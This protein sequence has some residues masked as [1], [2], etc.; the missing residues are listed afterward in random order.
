M[1]ELRAEPA[2]LDFPAA[3]AAIAQSH[4]EQLLQCETDCYDVHASLARRDPGFVLVDVRGP[5]HFAAG[6]IPGAVNI[7]Y[8]QISEQTLARY[9]PNT[10]FVVY[11]SGPHCNGADRAAAILS[12]LQRPVKKMIG[13]IEGW[14]WNGFELERA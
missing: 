11:C 7:P 1:P 14:R 5:E 10:V 13:G 8:R 9:S 6:H 2:A 3:P 12:R 4:F